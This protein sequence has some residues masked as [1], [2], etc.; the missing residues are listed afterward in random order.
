MS[1][2]ALQAKILQGTLL[3]CLLH[4]QLWYEFFNSS[5]S[6]IRDMVCSRFFHSWNKREFFKLK[7]F[8][9]LVVARSATLENFFATV[10]GLL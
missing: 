1:R 8:G 2:N 4:A 7:F 3:K 6:S 10:F 5:E 9:G